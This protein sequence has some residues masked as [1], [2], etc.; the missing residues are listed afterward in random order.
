MICPDIIAGA[1]NDILAVAGIKTADPGITSLP[2]SPCPSKRPR[3]PCWL[4]AEKDNNMKSSN[5]LV[6]L[7]KYS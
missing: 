4:R 7:I 6:R 5:T 2:T 1:R 3:L